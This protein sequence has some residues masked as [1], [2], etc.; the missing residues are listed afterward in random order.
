MSVEVRDPSGQV[1]ASAGPPQPLGTAPLG[2]NARHGL[3]TCGRR[4]G[5]AY[6][7]L[8]A[9]SAE[10][11]LRA[12]RTL[13]WVLAAA[14]AAA[15]AVVTLLARSVTR[16]ALTPLSSLTARIQAIEPGSGSRIGDVS[17]RELRPVAERFDALVARFEDA[18][19][20]ERRLT[21]QASHEL[22]TPLT[23]IRAEIEGLAT[24]RQDPG[25][26]LRAL[27]AI[28]RLS[29]LVET[30]LWFARAQEPLDDARMELVNLAD[31]VRAEAATR[32]CVTLVL[33][34]EALV[35]GDERL[36][37]R[38]VAN[39]IDN[40]L[41]YGQGESVIARAD[42]RDEELCLAITNAGQLSKRAAD[43]LF[44]PF[45]RAQETDTAVAGFGLGLSFARAVARAHG[46]ELALGE[47][48]EATTTF[49]LTLPLVA[50]SA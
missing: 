11:D 37:A 16:R 42:A 26:P 41:K 8:A 14:S 4:A 17:L 46:G 43:H 3:R 36:L 25:A 21:A 23:L 15:A 38:V 12:E 13:F 32:E 24:L 49:V 30:L 2:C 39:L 27:S 1:L 31:L 45:F 6:V 40:A 9:A 22:R 48:G 34:D 10:A 5:D 29:A 50:Y 44:E 18:L 47:S 35:R 19:A 7:V 33:P 28:D 20:R